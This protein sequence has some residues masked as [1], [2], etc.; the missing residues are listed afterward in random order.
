MNPEMMQ[1]LQALGGSSGMPPTNANGMAGMV[2]GATPFG[3]QNASL[4]M[5]QG[6]PSM[7][8]ALATP[9]PMTPA[10]TSPY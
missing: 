3:Q 1:M 10:P 5:Q 4:G 8:G 9:P 2:P 6:M 7:Y